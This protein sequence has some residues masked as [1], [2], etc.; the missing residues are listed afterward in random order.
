[1]RKRG[2]AWCRL[3]HWPSL[4]LTYGKVFQSQ[5]NAKKTNTPTVGHTVPKPQKGIVYFWIHNVACRWAKAGKNIENCVTQLNKTKK[6]GQKSNTFSIQT[7]TFNVHMY[8]VDRILTSAHKDKL[9]C[10]NLSSNRVYSM[11]KDLISFQADPQIIELEA[12]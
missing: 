8:L 6:S 2:V 9:G 1:M 12:Y 10:L 4:F 3:S 5:N 11:L 7:I